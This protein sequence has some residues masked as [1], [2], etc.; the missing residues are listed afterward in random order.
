MRGW[1]EQYL[2]VLAA[3]GRG[4]SDDLEALLEYYG[5]PFVFTTDEVAG[6]LLTPGQVLDLAR[7]QVDTMRESRY[8][9]TVVLAASVSVLTATGALLAVDL[10]R[11][12]ADETEIARFG[13]TYLILRGPEGLRI[14]AA[15]THG[16]RLDPPP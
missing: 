13:A 10:A 1:F 4:D 11:L 15:A 5:V 6:A 16:T 12:R 8:D 2:Q 9:H 7:Q 3:C 14:A